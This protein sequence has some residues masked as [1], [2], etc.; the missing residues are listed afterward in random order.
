MMKYTTKN[1]PDWLHNLPES[2]IA[3]GVEVFNQVARESGDDEKAQKAAWG[4][5]TAKY[6]KGDDGGWRAK[7]EV[8]GTDHNQT[9]RARA[10][11]AIDQTGLVWE[12]VIIEPGI[13]SSTPR[14]YWSEE[15]LSASAEIFSGV[16]INAYELTADFFSHLPIPDVGLLEDVKR[17]LVAKKVGWVEKAWWEEGVGI[18]AIIHFLPEHAWL[19]KALQH[20]IE[21][22]NNSVLGLSVDTRIKGVEV[23]VDGWT[24][25]WV[26]KIQSA[27][28][29][30]VVTY[31]AAGG[32]FL[33]AV[34]ALNHNME[35]NR[36]DREKLLKLI[37]QS[38]P[39]LLAGKDR[40]AL[41]EDEI[42]DLARMA[43]EKPA[44]GTPGDGDEN[45]RRAAQGISPEDIKTQIQAAIDGV[46]SQYEQRAACGRTLA[47]TL[48]DSGLPRPARRRIEKQFDGR[49]FEQTEL[50]NAVK[51]EKE[52]LAAMAGPG[53]APWGDQT[54]V[55]MGLCMRDKVQ[56]AVDKA[57]GLTQEDMQSFAR[58][59]RLNG[60]PFFEDLRV[61]QAEEFNA[62]PHPGSL[63]ELYTLLTGDPDVT[64]FFNRD[65][66]PAEL[67]AA[68]DISSSTFSYVL[69]NTL[70][71]R[72]VKDYLAVN[73]QE[74]LLISIRKPVRD[75]RTQEATL[76][77]Y[78]GDLDTVDP[79]TAD[80]QEISAVTDE[81]STY[82]IGQKGNILTI[83]RKTIIND[84][85]SL[86]QRLVSRIGRAARRTHAQY[87]WNFWVNNGTCSDGT[88]WF[89]VGHGNLGSTALSFSQAVADYI[90][91]G[92]MTEKDSGKR[93]GWLDDPSIKPTLIYPVDL[94][95]TGESIVNDEFY[96]SSNDLTT[97][98]RNPLKG[99][100]AGAQVSLLTDLTDW[101]L[102][103]PASAVDIVEMGYLNGRQEPEMFVADTPQSEQVFVADKIRHKIR[104][105]Y[106]GAVIDYRSGTKQVVA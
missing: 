36:M 93:I 78:F 11:K 49:A 24:V 52:Y 75:F 9:I 20:G 51:E 37:E 44:A 68:Q 89:T 74:D 25:I 59:S 63:R 33:R 54:R 35:G 76:V 12:A 15:V 34:A 50:E 28:S 58:M 31:P 7:A 27:S 5:I 19:P 97:K 10:A 106:A 29:V 30:D 23:N 61:A 104:H 80:Y 81:E 103:M 3:I 13:S 57:F 69:G 38:R 14:F 53:D 8:E 99:K 46:T 66:L 48:E 83:T 105:E 60:K 72:M 102:L 22:G 17:Y 79:E 84:D 47:K 90:V 88:A 62:V 26:L 41:S 21:Q 56:M 82:T 77:G 40:A 73:F 32:K 45:G 87:V 1:P 91:L 98:T 16:D 39:D 67:R 42:L 4:A 95:A 6:E 101:G 71:R 18:K 70:G 64:G 100:I 92:K 65:K 55:T 2:A 86:I 96:Y 85:I 43:M 94:V